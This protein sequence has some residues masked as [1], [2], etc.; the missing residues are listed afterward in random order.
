MNPFKLFENKNIN[1]IKL[2]LKVI[3]SL[4][5]QSEFK[6]YFKV[7]FYDYECIFLDVVLVISKN[8]AIEYIIPRI[9]ELKCDLKQL[10]GVDVVYI[11]FD[12]PEF[13]NLVDVEKI[14]P[15]D[16]CLVLKQRPEL[17]DFFDFNKFNYSDAYWL[18]QRQPQLKSYF[19]ECAFV[20]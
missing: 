17:A 9:L 5:L 6:N 2:G 15:Y 4:G 20:I 8:R 10:G 13:V 19:N 7:C 1:D 3:K 12:Y 16:S 11:L 18:L 14:S